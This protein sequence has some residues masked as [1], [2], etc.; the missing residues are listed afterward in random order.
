M[1]VSNASDPLRAI[2]AEFLVLSPSVIEVSCWDIPG[3]KCRVHFISDLPGASYEFE[4]S[5]ARL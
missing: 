2:A 4:Q 1:K 5:D 3:T